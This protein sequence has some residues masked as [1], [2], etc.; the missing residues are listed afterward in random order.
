MNENKKLKITI[1]IQLIA[2]VSLVAFIMFAVGALLSGIFLGSV[3]VDEIEKR[4]AVCA[5]TVEKD[6]EVASLKVEVH[7]LIDDFKARNGVDV[8]VFEGDIRLLTTLKN[9][10]G[11]RLT[12]TKMDPVILEAI[13]DGDTYFSRDTYINGIKYYAYYVP[14]LVDGEYVGAYFVGEPSVGIDTMITFS[15]GK[16]ILIMFLTGIGALIV[17]V[18]PVRRISIKLKTLSDRIGVLMQHDLTEKYTKIENPHDEIEVL[19]NQ[20]SDYSDELGSMMSQTKSTSMELK[21]IALALREASES[22]SGAS[23][24]ITKAIADIANGAASQADETANA[25]EKISSMASGLDIIKNNV[26]DLHTVI[27]FMGSIKTEVLKTLA[28]LQTINNTIVKDMNL[29]NSQVSVTSQS[30]DGIK[31]CVEV[32]NKITKQTALLSLN[33]S[34]E[35]ARAGEH[36]KGFAVV[37]ESIR[38][39]ADQSA[40]SS[41]EIE[42]ILVD[43]DKNYELII[44]NVSNTTTNMGIQSENLTETQEVFHKLE[45]N[46]DTTVASVTEI[47]KMVENIDAAIKD[48][49]D[50]ISNL[51][52]VS[53]ENS[54]S[55]Q[56]TMSN[57]EQLDATIAEVYQMAQQ[58]ENDAE[59][60]IAEVSVF[61]TE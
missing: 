34:I 61:K 30:V 20:T 36:G 19:T 33:A 27:E 55:T 1:K 40:A 46:I 24:E 43:L 11:E 13:K 57:I 37:A 21:D 29:T 14:V 9:S 56:Q 5:Y 7:S 6:C 15:M 45:D 54:A 2:T 8:S 41:N 22:T 52:A 42:T 25:T 28:D 12:G 38:T 17:S 60:L 47:A 16:I 4:F 50:V 10:D 18:F 53:E 35:A 44:Q 48:I 3:T 49:V 59:V 39:L 26:S 51:S 23:A 32:I 31:Q 58:V